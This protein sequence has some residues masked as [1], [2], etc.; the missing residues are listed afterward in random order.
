MSNR[1]R[2]FRRRGG[3]DDADDDSD[4]RAVSA[5]G[6]SASTSAKVQPKSAAAKP[7]KSATPVP[8]SRLSF[9]DDEEDADAT[10]VFR[11]SSSNSR[12]S[13]PLPSSSSSHHKL[14]S[15]KD[16]KSVSALRSSIPSNVQPQAGTYTLESLRELQKNT[17]SFASSRTAFP[18]AKLKPETT[19]PNEPVIVLKGLLKPSVPS[20]PDEE[21]EPLDQFENDEQKDSLSGDEATVRMA[22][23]GSGKG[24]RDKNKDSGDFIMDQASIDAIKA[25]R[26]R[27]RQAGPAAPD[28]IALDSGSN[29]GEA[30]G[31]S[32]EEPEYRGRIGFFGAK[33]DGEKKGV[34]E[35]YEDRV[36][37]KVSTVVSDG[38]LD[39][40][41]EEERLWEEE[42]ARKG[43][44][45]RLDEG[46]SK[47]S[48]GVNTG[49]NSVNVV[50]RAHQ[51]T[52]VSSTV[53]SD[54]YPSVQSS[55]MNANGLSIGGAVG[56]GLDAM[57][58][59]QQAE[60]TKKAL[61]NNLKMLEESHS[62]TLALCA[63]ND[64]NIAD[65]LS[66][67]TRLEKAF[68][69]AGEKFIFMQKLREFVSVICAFLQ[70][71]GPY[72]EELEERIKD[73]HEKR[74]A[75]I[76]ERRTA[77]NTDEMRE[78]EAAVAAA[79]AVLSKGGSSAATVEAATKAAQAAFAAAK[80]LKD[81]PVELDD[82]GRDLNLQKR[83]DMMRRAKS[84]QRRKD[85]YDLKRL[86][87]MEID[88]HNHPIEG[89]SSTDESDSETA[90]HQSSLAEWIRVSEQ[91]FSDAANDYAQLSAVVERLGRWKKEYALSYKDAYMPLSAPSIFSPYVRLELLK[92]DPLHEDS[93]F[94]DMKWH[95]LL[96]DYSAPDDADA[97][98]DANLIPDLV[99]KV[100]IPIL[101]HQLEKCWD[102]LSTRETRYAVSATT[103][104]FGYVS[105]SSEALGKMV[106]ALRD[107]LADA[108]T[109][110]TI[111]TWDSLVLKAVPNAARAAA[112]RFGVAVR[113]MR[114]ICLW[115]K[116][117]A[118]S[119]LE[120]LALDQLL[121]RKVL[122]HLR[123]IQSNIHDA[124]TR[125]E[126][127]VASLDGVWSGRSVTGDRS[128]KLQPL[129][130]YLLVL[131]RALEKRHSSGGAQTETS[132][133][134][135][136]LKK[137]LVDLNEYDHA[138]DIS[139]TFNLKEAL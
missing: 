5:N 113:L 119:A 137:M 71:K 115:N 83:I 25:R 21:I 92:W 33:I 135:R 111:P 77:E 14:T 40:E 35:A 18:E 51:Q 10:P 2:N 116:I 76:I 82:F 45:K 108:V 136:R 114:N 53:G 44:G 67:I 69:A 105:A 55:V 123:S 46:I 133:L 37:E 88:E 104:V 91:I 59:S 118:M 24:S 20:D 13:K 8:K 19:K 80:E 12:L 57:S 122:P 126:R 4:D 36:V 125:S 97:D 131:R 85:K 130:D 9:A 98:A 65:S 110:L 120:E 61:Y 127:V 129:V 100:A 75:A 68:S 17:K 49:I 121:N 41:D 58:I 90:A 106:A 11:P 32:D 73:L 60:V 39:D 72:I 62:K 94:I 23:I 56:T 38:D 42:Q 109:N 128:P 89:E 87:T 54:V 52:R 15:S 112:H 86:S 79:K 63:R 84:R 81:L 103:L 16:R 64:S 22:P 26:E 29:H 50:Q 30:E 96:F 66:N 93:D 124:M 139:K 102:M 43:L 48:V 3:D 1:A 28:Y 74:A 70:H 31:L 7:P 107:R 6:S 99:E 95:S 78:L 117:L 34:F 134:A 47:G 101:H 132:N 27:L 138:R